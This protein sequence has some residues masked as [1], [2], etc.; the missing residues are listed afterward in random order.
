MSRGSSRAQRFTLSTAQAVEHPPMVPS[1]MGPRSDRRETSESTWG[2]GGP[3]EWRI[4]SEPEH[5]FVRNVL[6]PDIAG[7]G[8]ERVP[9][10]PEAAYFST[11]PDWVC[12]V[13]SPATTTLDRTKKL[14]I[15][16]REQ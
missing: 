1:R 16:A 2:R 15:Y 10:L 12:E 3:G 5:H 4:L 13:L 8:R 14:R 6:V 11:P 7:W 9:R